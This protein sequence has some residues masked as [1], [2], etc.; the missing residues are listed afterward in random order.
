[1]SCP[2][3]IFLISVFLSVN[4]IAQDTFS[5]VA[6]DTITN[7]V[8]STGA[9]CTRLVLRI[10][11]LL[12]GLGAINSQCDWVAE[13]QNY[14]RSLMQ[15]GIAPQQIIDSLVTKDAN[16]DSSRRQYGII[17]LVDNGRTAAF[18]G[19][20]CR[21]YKNHILAKNYAIQGNILQGPQILDSMEV[22]FLTTAGDLADKL[23]SALQGAK[24]PGADTRCLNA[25]I[26]SSA[27]F[28]KVARPQDT[29]GTFFLDIEVQTED[30]RGGSFDPIDS[31]QTLFNEWRLGHPT[32]IEPADVV[33][34]LPGEFVLHQSYP[35]PFNPSTVIQSEVRVESFVSLIVYNLLGQKIKDLV[36]GNKEVGSYI[37][38][39]NG[40]DSLR[41]LVPSGI[42][43][44]QLNSA[45]YSQSKKMILLR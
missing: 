18:T 44:Y 24:V 25:G 17:D 34:F 13:N 31:L 27:A 41:E 28:I 15:Q 21:N 33:K 14:A 30:N 11:D 26:S 40:T 37:V 6:V 39:W 42:Y 29:T 35:N 9:S 23:M 20:N 32:G 1:M 43:I 4:L 10:G 19:S 5:I 45:N 8:G 22:R 12:P 3:L 16:G 2:K 38:T 7:E 36:S